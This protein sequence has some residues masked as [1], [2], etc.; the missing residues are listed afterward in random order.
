MQLLCLT[1]LLPVPEVS[2]VTI[3]IFLALSFSTKYSDLFTAQLMQ[4]ETFSVFQQAML[5]ELLSRMP[6]G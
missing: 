4:E 3:T 1:L 5:A 6:Q 2:T